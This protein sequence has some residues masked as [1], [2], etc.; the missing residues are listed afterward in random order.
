M[1][2]LTQVQPV[3]T[4]DGKLVALV[5]LRDGN[6]YYGQLTGKPGG[7]DVVWTPMKETVK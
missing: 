3:V 5:G 1:S 7:F 4:S 2:G 6:L